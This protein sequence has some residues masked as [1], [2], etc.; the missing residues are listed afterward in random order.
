MIQDLHAYAAPNPAPDGVA[1]C[2]N[3]DEAF[4]RCDLRQ[5]HDSNYGHVTRWEGFIAQW[6]NAAYVRDERITMA[7]A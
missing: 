3:V 2:E 1:T 6:G 5:G 4:G 7:L